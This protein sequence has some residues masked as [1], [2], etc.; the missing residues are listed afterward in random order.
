MAVYFTN[1]RTARELEPN[2]VV[3]G[4]LGANLRVRYLRYGPT[5]VDIDFQRAEDELSPLNDLT[6]V[7]VHVSD[8]ADV[9]FDVEAR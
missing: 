7:R 2:D 4:L 3:I 9:Q 1:P 6:V 8:S 5:G